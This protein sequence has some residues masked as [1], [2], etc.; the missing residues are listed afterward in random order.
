MG[1]PKA[2]F[3]HWLPLFFL[4]LHAVNGFSS[5]SHSLGP[6]LR[7]LV[8]FKATADPSSK[9][10]PSWN[11]ENHPCNWTGV[12][13]NARG[14][15]VFRLV[16]EEMNLTGSIL[17]LAS[18]S[19]LRVLSLKGNALAGPIPDLSNLTSL[20][21]LFLS[22]NRF[23]GPLPSSLSLLTRLF[24]LDLSFN[25]LSGNVPPSL[26]A[27]SHL[28]TLRL[29]GN[30][31][32][33]T[34]SSLNITTLRDLNVSGNHLAGP[35][36]QSLSGFPASAFA[37]NSALCGAPLPRCKAIVSDPLSPSAAGQIPAIV[38]SMPSTK[39]AG[40]GSGAEAGAT[41]GEATPPKRSGRMS[42][43]A[44]AAIVAA[45][46][47]VL[48]AVA[49]GVVCF[50][51]RSYAGRR[52]GRRV[53]EGEKIVYSSSSPC[54][55][56]GPAGAGGG[57]DRGRMVF[58]EGERRFELEDLLRASAE[59]L[60]KGGLGT[61]YKAVLDDGRAVAVKRLREVQV[62][63]R[64]EFEE[65]MEAIGRIHHPNLVG[66]TA[67]YYARDE[68]LLVSDYLP[69][70]SLFSLLHGNRGPGRTP[71]DW[72]SRMKIAI[73][74][75]RGLAY[76]HHTCRSPRIYHGNVKSTNVLLD[77]SGNACVV[78]FG[79][80]SLASPAVAARPTGYRAPEVSDG[81]KA[82]HKADV[83]SFGVLLLELLTGKSPAAPPEEGGV[84]LPRW[85]QS[86]VREE[87][88]SE[89][90]DLELM[91]YKNIEEEMVGMLQIALS[92]TSI[93]P[94]QRPKM[95][96]VVRMIEEIRGGEQ[97]PSHESF[98]SVSYSPSV[99]EDNTS[100]E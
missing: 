24:R 82:S 13:C 5:S 64:R 28:L 85:V 71:L 1:A 40:A 46:L 50:M 92:C 51:W 20:K 97:S 72:T 47:V 14:D 11:L 56:P 6:D 49:G 59:M 76:L 77:R 78:D 21:L 58:L 2:F 43:A 70:G 10:L 34:I 61:S 94:D 27:L 93:S 38:S 69:N 18:L 63:S 55:R 9:G 41:S 42:R 25:R 26:N 87:W 4:L 99:S 96:H 66:L 7:A 17:P 16:L 33:G 100:Q 30:L 83:Y 75:A 37:L 29:E 48:L 74:A 32:S 98:D 95:A 90:F 35:I 81:R 73:G 52:A 57:F 15:R 22:H 45:D 23:S 86:V 54:G 88:T 60:G 3:H 65:R 44:L 36:P 8:S 68:K 91:R 84:D 80:A 62:G 12:T 39:P 19:G 53:R 67:Y 79:L 89:V 31:L